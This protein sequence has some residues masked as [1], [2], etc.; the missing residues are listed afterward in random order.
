MLSDLFPTSQCF[1]LFSPGCLPLTVPSA[2]L[3][4]RSTGRER[5]APEF[6]S[7]WFLIVANLRLPF[8]HFRLS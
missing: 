1:P 8:D 6:F 3:V 2:S 5:F 7:D 4:M